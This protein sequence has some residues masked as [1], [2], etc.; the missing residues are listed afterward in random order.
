MKLQ[1]CPV[2]ARRYNCEV[3]CEIGN[4][5]SSQDPLCVNIFAR[6]RRPLCHFDLENSD[7]ASRREAGLPGPSGRPGPLDSNV[8]IIEMKSLGTHVRNTKRFYVVNPTDTSYEFI[9]E[10][11]YV[12]VGQQQLWRCVTQRGV[13]LSGKRY[14]MCFEYT[15]VLFVLVVFYRLIDRFL[16]FNNLK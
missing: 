9:W 1:F 11:L 4:L 10:P 12:P 13:V 2:D 14:E 6:S 15:R 7:Y 5:P 8:R 16:I 3:R